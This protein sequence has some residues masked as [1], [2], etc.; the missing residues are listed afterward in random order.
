M[1]CKRQL[2]ITSFRGRLICSVESIHDK[3]NIQTSY[4]QLLLQASKLSNTNR[5]VLDISFQKQKAEKNCLHLLP[6]ILLIDSNI[7]DFMI[8]NRNYDPSESCNTVVIVCKHSDITSERDIF[9]CLNPCNCSIKSIIS[10][11]FKIT[12]D[13]LW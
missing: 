4:E 5:V 7:S 11:L 6:S 1:Q 2:N 12:L 13:P 9:P 3:Q 10:C 8:Y